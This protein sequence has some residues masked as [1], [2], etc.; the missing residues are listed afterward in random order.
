MKLIAKV[1][2]RSG[3]ICEQCGQPGQR[4]KYGVL[5]TRC[6]DHTP[7]GAQPVAASVP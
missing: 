5:L 3:S 2:A 6:A 1:L 4:L 7:T